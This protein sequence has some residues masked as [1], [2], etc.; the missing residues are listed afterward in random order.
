MALKTE[1]ARA[2]PLLAT[3]SMVALETDDHTLR[4][5]LTLIGLPV[6]DGEAGEPGT[7]L[8]R[9]LASAPSEQEQKQPTLFTCEDDGFNE[10]L[11][12]VRRGGAGLLVR[13]YP[14]DELRRVIGHCQRPVGFAGRRVLVVEDDAAMSSLITKSLTSAGYKV[15]CVGAA[16]ELIDKLL[17]FHPD[18]LL[19]DLH[20]PDCTG[21]EMA[22]IVRQ[23]PGFAT[24]PILYVSGESDPVSQVAALKCGADGFITKPIRPRDLIGRIDAV[25]TRLSELDRLAHFDALTGVFNARAARLE[26]QMAMRVATRASAKLSVALIDVDHF[27]KVNDVHGHMVGDRVL[28]RLGQLLNRHFRGSDLVGRLGGEEFLVLMPGAS[29]EDASRLVDD[30]R[31]LFPQACRGAS[32]DVAL[33]PATFSAGVAE[34]DGAQSPEALTDIADKRL[35]RAKAGGRNQVVWSDGADG[36]SASG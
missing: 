2:A 22:L 6:A 3:I 27:K 4:R 26:L 12:C 30:A 15:D 36:G 13:P 31:R 19:L 25:V 21:A 32:E 28:Q 24:M 23:L 34:W 8:V 11:A 9:P 5:N 29:G 17:D 20:L 33:P 1:A 7:I 16:S 18:L 14:I 10:R 35:Y